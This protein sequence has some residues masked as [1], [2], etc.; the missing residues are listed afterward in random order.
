M[1]AKVTFIQTLTKVERL[2][3]V[4][5][6][7]KNKKLPLLSSFRSLGTD[8]ARSGDPLNTSFLQITSTRL[9][10]KKPLS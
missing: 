4:T 10:N 3:G 6:S 5:V 8:Y 9:Q 2:L 1:A 7:E